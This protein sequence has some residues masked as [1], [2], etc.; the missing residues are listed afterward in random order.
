MKIS[1]PL[2]RSLNIFYKFRLRNSVFDKIA[3][4]ILYCSILF[5]FTDHV[6]PCLQYLYLLA[7]YIVC[8][9]LVSYKFA[10]CTRILTST[11]NISQYLL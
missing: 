8:Y 5:T 2:L 3:I 10:F 9:M 4:A 11:T 7:Y 1:G 6:S